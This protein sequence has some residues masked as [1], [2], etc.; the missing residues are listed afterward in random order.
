MVATMNRS[1]E[2]RRGRADQAARAR[3]RPLVLAGL[4][5]CPRCDQVIVPDLAVKGEGWDTGHVDDLVAGGS[6]TGECRAE[7]AS[8][9]RSAGG[10]A[11]AIV[12]RGRRRPRLDAY[13]DPIEARQF[14]DRR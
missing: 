5:V 12:S 8:C 9:N 13:L 1:R 11:G 2:R 7:H 14:S 10:K 6:P 3:L 4:A